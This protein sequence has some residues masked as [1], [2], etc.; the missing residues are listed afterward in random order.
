MIPSWRAGTQAR[1][2][3]PAMAA[4]EVSRSTSIA[5]SADR[6]WELVSDLPGMGRFSPEN[7]GGRWL[8]SAT[9]PAL[10]ARFRGRNGSGLRRWSTSCTVVRCEPGR[11]FAFEVHFARVPVALWSYE[12]EPTDT[13]CRLTETWQDRRSPAFA[14]AGALTTGV[15]DRTGFTADS[16]EQTLS[17]VKAVAEQV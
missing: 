7:C 10:G 9:G 16:I 3:R 4:P 11:A 14:R 1:G 15:S 6:V 13:G 8:G 17:A 2:Y 12:V 5:A